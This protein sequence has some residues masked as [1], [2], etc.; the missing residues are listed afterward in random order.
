MAILIERPRRRAQA[1]NLT[2]LIDVV[3][4]LI[5]FFMLSTTFVVSESLE[6][7][8]PSDRNGAPPSDPDIAVFRVISDGAIVYD[9]QRLELREFTGKVRALISLKPEQNVLVLSSPDVT[10]QQ[11]VTVLDILYMQGATNVQIDHA[12]GS[13]VGGDVRFAQ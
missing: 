7:G 11:L 10:V 6:L 9:D 8:L 1:V 2:P 5:V 4:L 3:F 13:S 12:P